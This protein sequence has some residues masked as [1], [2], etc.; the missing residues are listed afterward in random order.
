MAYK[1]RKLAVM[2]SLLCLIQTTYAA[3]TTTSGL[4]KEEL[5][6]AKLAGKATG[7][8]IY[9]GATVITGNESKSD[10]AIVVNGERIEAI[11][12]AAQV[13]SA[14][15]TETEIVD[16]HHLFVLPGLIDSHVHYGTHPNLSFAQAQLKRDVYAGITGVRDMAGDARFL[17][18]MSRASLIN[19]IP[20]PDIYYAS[21]VAGPSFFNDPRT[22]TSALGMPPGTA[23]WMYAVTDKTN[24]AMTLS[25]ARGTG[26]TGLKIYANLPGPLVQRLVKEANHQ[27]F[28]VWTHLQVYPA[29]PYDSLGATSVSHVCMIARY[30]AQPGKAKYGHQNEPSYDDMSANNAE[31]KKY[32]SALKKSGTI[33]D[34]TLSVY[35]LPSQAKVTADGKTKHLHCSI[36]LAGEITHAMLVAGIPI[37]AGTDSNASADDAFPA[38]NR[39]LEYL[40]KYAGL[41][42]REAILSATEN[43][44]KALG[45]EKEIGSIE[46]G[47]FAN[48]VFTKED[49]T[50]DIAHLRSIEFTVKRGIRF[51]RKDY[52]HQPIPEQDD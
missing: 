47:K 21:L 41:S 1:T 42:A 30:A 44:A 26:A 11:I 24:M 32:I 23:P 15:L 16:V 43:A 52:Q 38:L 18:D 13:N 7:K 51:D 40:V 17:G 10:M 35:E 48:L 39:E 20:A 45:K 19:E 33:M 14:S 27:H 6:T 34:A 5:V 31:I 37:V 36:E 12:P 22:V 25:Q 49:P 29:T 8:V 9:L 2:I 50:Q 4:S 28:P 3:E 46:T